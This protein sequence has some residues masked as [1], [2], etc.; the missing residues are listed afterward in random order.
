MLHL[1]EQRLVQDWDPI[2]HSTPKSHPPPETALYFFFCV[3][4]V[5]FLDKYHLMYKKYSMTVPKNLIQNTIHRF[6]KCNIKIL[7]LDYDNFV[8]LA[9]EIKIGS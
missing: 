1:D 7:K 2:Y 3:L 4:K 6:Y 8:E 5:K 9:F